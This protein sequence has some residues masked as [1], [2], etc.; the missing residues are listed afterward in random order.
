VV[1]Q[2]EGKRPGQGMQLESIDLDY[3][4]VHPEQAA[5]TPSAY[6]HLL[7][8][9]LRGD[10]TYFARADEVEAA[11]AAVEPVVTGWAQ[12]E[13]SELHRYTAGSPGLAAADELLARDGRRWH[14]THSADDAVP[15]HR[16]TPNDA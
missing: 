11:W 8:D 10:P 3:C 13:S 5:S 9:A 16:P 4:Y 15:R 14:S 6:E 2:V 7:L 12:G 1:I